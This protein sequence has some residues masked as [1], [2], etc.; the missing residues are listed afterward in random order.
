MTF[1][2]FYFSTI[3]ISRHPEWTMFVFRIIIVPPFWAKTLKAF[4]PQSQNLNGGFLKSTDL[5]E[6]KLF[7]LPFHWAWYCCKVFFDSDCIE[8][9]NQNWFEIGK[10]WNL[11]AL[12][13]G[14][15]SNNT[16]SINRRKNHFVKIIAKTT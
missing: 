4:S 13:E 6:I 16:L 10:L 1:Q 11:L 7:N 14:R 9:W 8:S 2:H 5:V 15:M 3:C 12:R